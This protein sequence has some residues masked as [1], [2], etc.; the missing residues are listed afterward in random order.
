MPAEHAHMGATLSSCGPGLCM[1]AGCSA[2]VKGVKG[3]GCAAA[4]GLLL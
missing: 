3:A 1:L 4:A 2:A